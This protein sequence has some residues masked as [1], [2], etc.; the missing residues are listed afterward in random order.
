MAKNIEVGVEPAEA[1]ERK[2]KRVPTTLGRRSTEGAWLTYTRPLTTQEPAVHGVYPDR[3][4]AGEAIVSAL[5]Q[6]GSPLRRVFVP[7]GLTLAEVL[8]QSE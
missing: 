7:W 3:E 1:P 8:A 6:D 4:S 2:P 5:E